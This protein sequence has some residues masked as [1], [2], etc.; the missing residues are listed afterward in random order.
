MSGEDDN[1]ELASSELGTIEYWDKTYSTEIQNFEDHGDIGEVWFGED[2][3][4]RVVR[5]LCDN[6]EVKR[7][8]RILDVGCGN[9]MLLIELAREKFCDLTGI[10]YSQNAIE[11]ANAVARK[12]N[13]D[14]KYYVC[15][16][17]ANYDELIEGGTLLKE[18]DIVLDKGTYD[19]VSLH[20]VDAKKKR[21]KYIENIHRIL[22][23]TGMFVITSCNWTQGELISHFK[24]KFELLDIIP[25]PKFQ[26]GGKTGSLI[27][28]LVL[29]KC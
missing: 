8:D 23:H 14:I 24:A 11:L 29:R 13:I 3:A 17:L 1:E 2:S 12:Q 20:P 25:T 28:S 21:E 6:P 9:G 4:L 18:Y 10:D 5:W 16:M 27:T 26:F 7:D 15:D 22:S 19:A